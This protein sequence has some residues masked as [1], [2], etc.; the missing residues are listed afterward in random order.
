[1]GFNSGFK[2]LKYLSAVSVQAAFLQTRCNYT[3]SHSGTLMEF[4]NFNTG[5]TDFSNYVVKGTN[6]MFFVVETHVVCFV[7]VC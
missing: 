5:S 4:Y 1:M 6:R 2:G 3:V 7:S